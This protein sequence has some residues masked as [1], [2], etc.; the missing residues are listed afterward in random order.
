MILSTVTYLV[1]LLIV[2]FVLSYGIRTPV[3]FFRRK[4]PE[5]ARAASDALDLRPS[6]DAK[7]MKP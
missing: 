4:R 3:A 7:A 2:G 5:R 6:V 1:A